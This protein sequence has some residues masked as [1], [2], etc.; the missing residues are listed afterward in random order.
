MQR[1]Q[2]IAGAPG[3][4]LG[5]TAR[6]DTAPA[7]TALVAAE[8]RPAERLAAIQADVA[9]HLAQLAAELRAMGNA[10]EA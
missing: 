3:F 6:V 1:L 10:S 9:A 7:P 8:D 2:G 4:A 5:K